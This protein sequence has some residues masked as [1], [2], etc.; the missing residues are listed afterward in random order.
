MTILMTLQRQKRPTSPFRAFLAP[1]DPL[2][3]S[4]GGL[5]E[6]LAVWA[7]A[8]ALGCGPSPKPNHAQNKKSKRLTFKVTVKPAQLPREAKKAKKKG[9]IHDAML[10]YTMA[11]LHG[12]MTVDELTDKLDGIQKTIGHM[13][14]CRELALAAASAERVQAN[15]LNAMKAEAA[16]GT[17]KALEALRQRYE[18]YG[19]EHYCLKKAEALVKKGA[20]PSAVLWYFLAAEHLEMSRQRLLTTLSRLE[21]NL[22]KGSPLCSLLGQA[23]KRIQSHRTKMTKAKRTYEAAM[24]KSVSEKLELLIQM[25]KCD[26][27]GI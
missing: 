19:C 25:K 1:A 20:Y 3:L 17:G 2:E 11:V 6:I 4:R 22:K 10:I 5:L 23:R 12:K 16:K 8:S 24:A 14:F 26:L 13:G 18:D 7:L 27:D 21:K 9:E 15:Y